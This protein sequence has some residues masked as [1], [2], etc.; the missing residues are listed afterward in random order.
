M[1]K[2][3]NLNLSEQFMECKT[4]IIGSGYSSVGYAMSHEDTLIVESLELTDPTFGGALRSFEIEDIPQK[5]MPSYLLYDYLR[6]LDILE[7]KAVNASA[8][9]CGLSGFALERDISVLL[10]SRVISAQP[11]GTRTECRLITNSGIITVLADKVI[12][13]RPSGRGYQSFLFTAKERESADEVSR[14]F[15]DGRVVPAFYRD[16]Y[17][18]ILPLRSDNSASL[19]KERRYSEWGRLSLGAKLLYTAPYPF[20]ESERVGIP[21]DSDFLD[22]FSALDAGYSYDREGLI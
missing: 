7:G 13:M 20:F 8:L 18:L 19:A 14:I 2:T 17:A 5:D 12:D 22:P 9:E 21:R 15:A 1:L 3:K 6:S 10:K 16:R 11:S 4:L